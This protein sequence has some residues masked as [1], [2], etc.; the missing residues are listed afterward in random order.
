M[1]SV[2]PSDP[3]FHFDAP[4]AIRVKRQPALKHV[5]ACNNNVLP[6]TSV[7]FCTGPKPIEPMQ[8]RKGF[9]FPVWR[10]YQVSENK[11][12]ISYQGYQAYQGYQGGTFADSAFSRVLTCLPEPRIA[13]AVVAR[14]A[15]SPCPLIYCAT[16]PIWVPESDNCGNIS[17]QPRRTCRHLFQGTV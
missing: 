2:L 9:L 1:A 5:I 12:I 8:T 15:C 13:Q 10:I 7:F 17:C 4:L 6:C 16:D 11:V 3:P 14:L